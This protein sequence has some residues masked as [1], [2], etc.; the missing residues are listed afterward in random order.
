MPDNEREVANVYRLQRGGAS[1]AV[2]SA[3]AL[4]RQ[5][6]NSPALL[7]IACCQTT[8]LTSSR[9]TRIGHRILPL[10]FKEAGRDSPVLLDSK[11]TSIENA[12]EQRFNPRPT[13][14]RFQT[15]RSNGMPIDS[16]WPFA[17]DRHPSQLAFQRE[18]CPGSQ[19]GHSPSEDWRRSPLWQLY[20]PDDAVSG[21]CE[22]RYGRE[23]HAGYRGGS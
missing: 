8:Y 14:Y 3:R 17:V 13:K 9:A 19:T 12:K 1:H 6:K 20:R 2:V 4:W 5:T 10:S 7:L 15:I 23:C 21:N 16:V 22:G 11:F 18:R